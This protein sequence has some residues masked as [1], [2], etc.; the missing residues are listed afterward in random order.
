MASSAQT[1]V[2]SASAVLLSIR[3]LGPALRQ[4][5]VRDTGLSTATVARTVT[6]LA[7]AGLIRERPDLLPPGAVGRPSVPVEADGRQHAVLGIHLGQRVITTALAAPD[8]RIL[9]TGRHPVDPSHRPV[10]PI[11]IAG[12]ALRRAAARFPRHRVLTIGVV[13]PWGDLPWDPEDLRGRLHHATGLPVAV[14]DHVAALAGADLLNAADRPDGSTLYLYARDTM[15]FVV[16][17]DGRLPDDGKVGR[18]THLPTGSAVPCGCG[19]V[20]CLGVTAGDRHLAQRAHRDGIVARPSIDAV[21]AAA[22][23]G[24]RAALALL[25]DR[26]TVLG[27][28]TAVVG[29]MLHP[30]RIVL[31]GQAFTG[32]PRTFGELVTAFRATSTLLPEPS[33]AWMG[34]GVQAVAATSCALRHLYADPLR[35]VASASASAHRRSRVA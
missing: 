31:A 27:R 17:S 7:A 2:A 25:R 24:D 3:R 1:S 28:A 4:D 11:E 30:D 21:V 6:G 8:G 12:R 29:D 16:A 33:F 22:Q 10:D 35:I 9:V 26:A 20:G 15:A 23:D 19:A 18:L 14:A 13:G 32:F 34:A 5:L